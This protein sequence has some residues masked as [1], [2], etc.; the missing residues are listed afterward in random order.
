MLMQLKGGVTDETLRVKTGADLPHMDALKSYFFESEAEKRE[1]WAK[2]LIELIKLKAPADGG[3]RS[4]A[5]LFASQDWSPTRDLTTDLAHRYIAAGMFDPAA[6]MSGVLADQDSA[7]GM[8]CGKTP[9]ASAIG[10]ENSAAVRFLCDLG[11][12]LNIGKVMLGGFE[13]E[14]LEYAQSLA[15]PAVVAT[16]TESLM[17]RQLDATSSSLPHSHVLGAAPTQTPLTP[18]HLQSEPTAASRRRIRV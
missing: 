11:A 16:L 18:V 17:R 2:C 1:T 15:L 13:R 9:L 10:H 3:K 12:S 7:F 14:A 8:H 4:I 5:R 6:P